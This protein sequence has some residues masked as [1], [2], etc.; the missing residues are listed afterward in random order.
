M[1]QNKK[2]EILH[3][4]MT[5]ALAMNTD[6][7]RILSNEEIDEL[8]QSIKGITG[9]RLKENLLRKMIINNGR[10]LIGIIEVAQNLLNDKEEEKIFTIWI[11]EDEEEH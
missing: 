1:S 6:G 10:S 8:V 7:N 4:L 5:V 2:A 9:V 3:Y 11:E